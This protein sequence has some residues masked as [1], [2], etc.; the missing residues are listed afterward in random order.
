MWPAL[1]TLRHWVQ[2]T[3][4]VDSASQVLLSQIFLE[5]S[6]SCM[7]PLEEDCW[8]SPL[9][10]P[11]LSPW[12]FSFLGLGCVSFTVRNHSCE[13][14]GLWSPMNSPAEPWKLGGP[15]PKGNNFTEVCRSTFADTWAIRFHKSTWKSEDHVLKLW[16]EEKVWEDR[17]KSW[18]V[19]YATFTLKHLLGSA[20]VLLAWP[21]MNHR[22]PSIWTHSSLIQRRFFQD[23]GMRLCF[24]FNFYW[25]RR[26]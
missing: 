2:W 26:H 11:G 19:R 6:P 20:W 7:A 24:I 5:W 15:T 21:S 1:M 8:S 16:P 4:L 9:D 13:H 18:L 14:D 23:K 3:A 12:V 17:N 25:R 10:S 22:R